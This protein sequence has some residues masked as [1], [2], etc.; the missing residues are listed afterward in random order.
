MISRHPEETSAELELRAEVADLRQR[1]EELQTTQKQARVPGHTH[2][3]AAR[4]KPSTTVL[5]SL[6]IIILVLGVAA[7]FGGYLPALRNQKMLVDQVTEQESDI[8]VVNVAVV[9]RSP[10]KTQLILPG[11]IQAVTEAPVLARASGYIKQ[12]YADIGDRVKQ[13]DLLAEI[14]SPELGQQVASTRATLLQITAAADQA[15]AS[16]EQGRA[17]EQL[18]KVTSERYQN[19]VERGAVSRQDSDN[20]RAQF[21]ASHA[22]V[23]ALVKA[24]AAARGSVGAATANLNRLLEVQ[25]YTRVKAPFAGVITVRNVDTGA[26]VNEGNTLMFRIAQTDRLRI[27]V[28]LPQGDSTLVHQGMNATLRIPDLPARIFKGT[29]TRTSNALDPNTRTMLAEVQVENPEA[30][31]LP[32]M[33]AQINFETMRALP[34]MIIKGDA[35]VIRPEGP[36]VA[37]ITANQTVHFQ[38]VEL[39]R[40][41]GDTVEVLSGLESGQQIIVNPGDSAAEGVKV[42]PV[43]IVETAGRGGRGKR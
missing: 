26:L 1:L 28:N 2:P 18:S 5:L 9:E 37:V 20:F 3:A 33:Y 38:E 14:D 36:R 34:P 7:F 39:G 31:L 15:Q 25:S 10:Q 23:A 29:V 12:R 4:K 8:P 6:F 35:L 41:F 43:L 40:D 27:Y 22:N 42:K 13:G 11:N 32:G 17:N 30:L 19:L 21:D 24:E 16:L